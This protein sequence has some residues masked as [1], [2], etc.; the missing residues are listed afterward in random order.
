MVIAAGAGDLCWREGSRSYGCCWGGE[1][2]ADD[3]LGAGVGLS[4][5]RGGTG[6]PL[7]MNILAAWPGDLGPCPVA[8]SVLPQVM[9]LGGR[10]LTSM[11]RTS[12]L[13]PRKVSVE[14]K[15]LRITVN[16]YPQPFHRGGMPSLPSMYLVVGGRY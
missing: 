9:V 8:V 4:G 11:A 12:G 13:Y 7:S 5:V 1:P 6:W 2:V 14:I 16:A 15:R 10:A 3:V